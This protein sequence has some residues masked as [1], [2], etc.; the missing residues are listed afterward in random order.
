MLLASSMAIGNVRPQ[1]RQMCNLPYLCRGSETAYTL[2]EWLY[3][4]VFSA[5]DDAYHRLHPK[6][7]SQSADLAE[8]LTSSEIDQAIKD[9]FVLLDRDLIEG[10]AR[11][12]EGDRF[13]NDAMS[14]VAPSYS[15]SCALFS[16]YDM[17]KQRLKVACSGDSRA[18]LGRRNAAGEWKALALSADQTGYNKDEIARIH[19]EHPG[20]PN[21]I[22]DGRLLGMAVTRAFGD[23]IWKVQVQI[24]LH[25]K[26][27]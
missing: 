19:A 11:A 16:L 26:P 12:I 27:S 25:V 17:Q 2:R 14:E 15:G 24:R 23:G 21:V 4:Y 10:A 6:G 7:N 9:A 18:V 22:Q 1:C 13:L 8:E 3:R 20:E 5:I